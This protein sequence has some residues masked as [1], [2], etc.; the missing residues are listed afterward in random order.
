MK[1]GMV[2]WEVEGR[3]EMGVR[4]GTCYGGGEGG[5]FGTWGTH[6]A[7]VAQD[8]RADGLEERRHRVGQAAQA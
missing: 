7:G 6:G 8:G 3:N 2:N 5:A 4:S 1:I